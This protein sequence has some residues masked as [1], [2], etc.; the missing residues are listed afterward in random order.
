M[1]RRRAHDAPTLPEPDPCATDPS[2]ASIARSQG[3]RRARTPRLDEGGRV[4]IYGI[5]AVEAALRNPQ[6]RHRASSI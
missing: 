4:L 3:S 2:R 6:P 5:H 1:S